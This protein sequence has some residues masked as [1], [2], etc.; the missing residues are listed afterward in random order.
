MSK[1][2]AKVNESERYW[3]R[4]YPLGIIAEVVGWGLE[5][6]IGARQ[7]SEKIADFGGDCGWSVIGGAWA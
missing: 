1:K 5:A 7:D 3:G 4:S 2:Y 6:K